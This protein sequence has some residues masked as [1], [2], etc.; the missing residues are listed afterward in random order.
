MYNRQDTAV[1]TYIHTYIHIYIPAC[2]QQVYLPSGR[3]VQV[4]IPRHHNV[5]LSVPGSDD[6]EGRGICGTLDGS[7]SGDKAY[8]HRN[9]SVQRDACPS[10]NCVPKEF[11]ES[12]R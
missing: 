11:T 12:W 6:G 9:G 2:W 5:A 3:E 8:T 10:R 7:S 1:C 4:D